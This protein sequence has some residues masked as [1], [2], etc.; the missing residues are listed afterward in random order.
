MKTT[1]G[2]LGG[3]SAGNWAVSDIFLKFCS[4]GES[5]GIGDWR[6]RECFGESRQNPASIRF[7]ASH[8]GVSA[9]RSLRQSVARKGQALLV[10]RTDQ[11]STASR[12]QSRYRITRIVPAGRSVAVL[13]YPAARLKLQ[14]RAKGD[15]LRRDIDDPNTAAIDV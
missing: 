7:D 1:A 6:R 13:G 11:H 8:S 12:A 15:R 4:V 14:Q 3:D 2:I 5:H 10:Q 9:R